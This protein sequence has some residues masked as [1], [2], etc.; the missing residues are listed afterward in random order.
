MKFGQRAQDDAVGG[1]STQDGRIGLRPG[2]FDESLVDDPQQVGPRGRQRQAFVHRAEQSGRVA[3]V[4]E[5]HRRARRRLGQPGEQGGPSV[6]VADDTA[7]D[8]PNVKPGQATGQRVFAERRFDDGND[9]R[10]AFFERAGQ[11]VDKLVA[12]VAEREA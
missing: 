1:H 3:G 5:K 12:A 8:R 6:R 11:G 7:P 4:G 10:P 2:V 9:G